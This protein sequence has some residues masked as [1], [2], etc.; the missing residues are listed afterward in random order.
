MDVVTA[1][2]TDMIKSLM[3]D[4][5]QKDLKILEQAEQRQEMLTKPSGALGRLEIITVELAAWQSKVNPTLDNV[6]CHIFAGNH[7]IAQRGVSAFP[8][9]VT[10]QMVQN[11][12]NG[13]AAIN[14]LCE[15]YGAKL[16]VTEINLDEPTKDFT[17]EPAMSLL[18][19]EEAF[20]IGQ[21]Q[22]DPSSDLILVG[23]M[24]IGNSTVAAAICYFL[25]GGEPSDWTGKGTGVNEEIIKR[26][27]TLLEEAMIQHGAEIKG[28]PLKI[29]QYVGGREFAAL[30]GVIFAARLH[31]VPVILDGF[32]STAAAAILHSM[33]DTA[34]KHCLAGHVSSEQ[35]HRKLLHKVRLKPLINFDMRLGEGSG[36]ALALG[37]LRGAVAVHNGMS[38]F[39]EAAVSHKNSG[40]KQ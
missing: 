16:Q 9:S 30:C 20:A 15:A 39:E 33:N 7:G 25:Y 21:Y 22:L 23:E 29:L 34:L 37:V 24:G 38:T 6:Q 4:L 26:K 1:F 27:N 2:T 31:K 5:P 8:S 13:G 17:K 10:A 32:I 18:E 11:F 40:V 12:E 28:N 19:T 35:A 36:A 14:Q 3:D